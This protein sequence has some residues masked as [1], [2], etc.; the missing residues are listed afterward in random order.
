MQ[1][2][3]INIDFLYIT[4]EILFMLIGITRMYCFIRINGKYDVSRK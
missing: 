4:K 3:Q 2:M 1:I